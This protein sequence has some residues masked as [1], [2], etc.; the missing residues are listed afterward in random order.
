MH[1]ISCF[2]ALEPEINFY[3]YGVERNALEFVYK[4]GGASA[5]GIRRREGFVRSDDGNLD[6]PMFV[7]S[8]SMV[9]VD[10]VPMVRAAWRYTS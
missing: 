6:A 7:P 8:G 2:A 9:N 4:T 10:E 1:G 5:T 3:F